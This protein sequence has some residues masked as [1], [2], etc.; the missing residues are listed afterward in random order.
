MLLI[1]PDAPFQVAE[2]SRHLDERKIGNR[3]LFGGNLVRQPA[4]VHLRRQQ[5][6]AFRVVG[7][8]A[9]AD[10]LMNDALFVGVYPGLTVPMLDYMVEVLHEFCRM[11]KAG[12]QPV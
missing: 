8:L 10:R 11:K 3:R 1:R 2:L 5:P 7:D 12:K 6:G 4:F 9:G